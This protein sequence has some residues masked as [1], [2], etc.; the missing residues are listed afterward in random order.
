MVGPLA[1]PWGYHDHLLQYRHASAL[2]HIH[3]KPV[4]DL[5]R[6]LSTP[7]AQGLPLRNIRLLWAGLKM[8]RGRPLFFTGQ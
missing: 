1:A 6:W 7:L 3:R 4:A 8:S 5:S 2:T